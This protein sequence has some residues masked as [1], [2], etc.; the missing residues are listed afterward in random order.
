MIGKF[1]TRR[2][3]PDHFQRLLVVVMVG[4]RFARTTAE[5]AVVRANE[6]S[7]LKSLIHCMIRPL[8]LREI[9]LVHPRVPVEVR[10]MSGAPLPTRLFA[11]FAVLVAVLINIVFIAFVNFLRVGLAVLAVPLLVLFEVCKS[12]FSLVLLACFRV[13]EWHGSYHTTNM[14]MSG[15]FLAE[16]PFI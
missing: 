2:T 15:G 10:R 1:M 4:M 16:Q 13:F 8:P 9:L 3:Q 12:V 7:F 5:N 14:L 6:R 11:P